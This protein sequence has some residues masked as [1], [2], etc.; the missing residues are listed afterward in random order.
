MARKIRQ[1]MPDVN[2][3]NYLQFLLDIES[4][5]SNSRTEKLR[6]YDPEKGCLVTNLSKLPSNRL[7]FGTGNPDFIFPM[8]VGKNSAAILADRD[9]YILRMV[10]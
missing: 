1:N 7:N 8:T 3:K 2:K 9:N 10:Y 5:I 6:P 4:D